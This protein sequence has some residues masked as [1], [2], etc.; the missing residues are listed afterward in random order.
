MEFISYIHMEF[1]LA[2]QHVI[3]T[4]FTC[5]L[6]ASSVE[7]PT[8]APVP[9]RYKT[10]C[11]KNLVILTQY[12]TEFWSSF[13]ALNIRYISQLIYL[14]IFP[15]LFKDFWLIM[16]MQPTHVTAR[17]AGCSGFRSLLKRRNPSL[18][19]WWRGRRETAYPVTGLPPDKHAFVFGA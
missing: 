18:W 5:R 9:S 7:S 8:V 19:W 6:Q 3:Q 14:F 2:R 1:T 10:S 4:D 11:H 16:E 12:S 15:F 13:Q 17:Q